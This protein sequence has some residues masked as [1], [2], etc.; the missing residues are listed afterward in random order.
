M[1]AKIPRGADLPRIA[2]HKPATFAALL[3][4]IET[5]QN[6]RA[7][8]WY[9]GTGNIA[10]GLVPTIGRKEPVP[11]AEELNGLEKGI[12][13]SFAQ[14]S[15]PFLDRELGGEWKNLFF[16]QHY[17]IPTRLLDWSESP[18]V[19]LYFALSSVRRGDDMKPLSDVALWMC[20]PDEWNRTALS[21]ISY[22]GGILDEA[23]EEIKSYSPNMDLE[24]RATTP[25]MIYGT[26]NSPRIVAQRGVFALFGKA[27]KSMQDVYRETAFKAGTLEVIVIQKDHIDTIFSSLYRKGFSESTIYPDLSGLALEIRRKFG[28]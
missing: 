23:C 17:G 13:N 28:Y 18:F 12:A 21:H 7:N 4:R 15:P 3:S 22:P 27:L 14:R 16:M 8:S 10:H 1:S 2:E 25:V 6:G 9:R 19:A 26:H 20:D 24:Q 5:F 11:S